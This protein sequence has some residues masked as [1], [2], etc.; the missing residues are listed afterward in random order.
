[1]E[2]QHAPLILDGGLPLVTVLCCVV[3]FCGLP[4]F[5]LNFVARPRMGVV[6]FIPPIEHVIDAEQ[7]G[8]LRERGGEQSAI[9]RFLPQQKV[10]MISEPKCLWRQAP[11]ANRQAIDSQLTVSR[12][13]LAYFNTVA[14]GG[15][16]LLVY[17]T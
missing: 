16:I 6:L 7:N 8:A 13:S 11:I 9:P 5:T 10:M 1:M 14:L 12:P 15:T 4:C 2:K 3:L 17:S